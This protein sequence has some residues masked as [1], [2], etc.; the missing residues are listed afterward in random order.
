M[1]NETVL[2]LRCKILLLG[3]L[4]LSGGPAVSVVPP[5]GGR[6]ELASAYVTQT[7][8]PCQE[9]RLRFM[10]SILGL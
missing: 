8:D 7:S 10:C 3:C 4:L 9:R 6:R 2:F 5:L 1:C